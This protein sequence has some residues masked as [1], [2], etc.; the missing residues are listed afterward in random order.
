MYPRHTA[1]VVRIVKLASKYGIPLIPFCAGTSVE[2][3]SDVF[4]LASSLC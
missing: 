3:L 2:G 1:D 4:M